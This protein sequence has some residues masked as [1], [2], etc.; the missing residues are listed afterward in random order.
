MNYSIYNQDC[1]QGLKDNVADN[2]VDLIFT[3]PPYGIQG[4]K[5]DAH[6]ARDEGNVVSGYI[7]VPFENYE[8]FS[9]D[10][11]GECAR[12]LRPG[13]SI[14][15]VTGYTGLRHILNALA[16][17]ELVEVNHLIW[18]FNFSVYTQK[19]YASSHYHILYWTKPPAKKV[20]FNTYCRFE[21]KTDSY[22]D[23][24]DVFQLNRD[25]K[26]GERKNKN[27]LPEDLVE[28]FI[29]YSSNRGDVVLDPF[30]GGFTTAVVALR[31]GRR[32]IGFELNENAYNEFLPM[33]AEVEEEL[34]PAP[35]P[36]NQTE[37]ARRTKMRTE[38]N[39]KR[40]EKKNKAAL[41]KLEYFSPKEVG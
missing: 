19:K 15:I 14:Y 37:L 26:P 13:G 34:D 36:P 17:T 16:S 30:M 31:Y 2:S 35:T 32:V 10:W 5:L 22:H 29:L 7:D 6:Y 38:R 1:I 24:C 33:L 21:E 25:Y 40:K 27:Q 12:V 28:K 39:R 9:R 8:Q 20:T 41:E 4:D 23:R 18:Q 3:D 11:I